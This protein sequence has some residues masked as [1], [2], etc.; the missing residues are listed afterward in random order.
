[1]CENIPSYTY[2]SFTEVLGF[3]GQLMRDQQLKVL[4][5]LFR[6]FL[7]AE[8]VLASEEERRPY[9]C[10]GLSVY[11]RLPLLVVLPETMAQISKIVGP[12]VVQVH[13]GTMLVVL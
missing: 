5:G 1:M 11:R 7:S 10:D 4:T 6:Q 3:K 8:S 12:L 9:E 2:R 13:Q